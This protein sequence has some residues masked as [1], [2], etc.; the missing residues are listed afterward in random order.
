[1]NASD[2]LKYGDSFL[3]QALNEV[4][5]DYWNI[6]GVCGV[7][8]VKDIMAHLVSYE[9]MLTD[10]L[11]LVMGVDT[12]ATTYTSL[13]TDPAFNDNF[14]GDYQKYTSQEVLDEYHRLHAQNLAMIEE[15][16]LE[17]RRQL[18][19]VPNY[20]D[21]YDLEDYL[22]YSFYGHKREHGAQISVFKD[23]LTQG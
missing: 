10:V 18:G 3:T 14:V 13:M 5:Q 22:V 6:N 21:A 12:P 23:S 11:N 16:P 1:M 4:A 19:V 17:K 8:S 20:G 9:L 2:I 15:I 7:W